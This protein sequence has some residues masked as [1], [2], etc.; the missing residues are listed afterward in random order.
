MPLNSVNTNVAAQ[1]ALK[2]LNTTATQLQ[3]TQKQ[4]STGYRAA[5][6]TD[7]GGAFAVA[8]RVRGDIAALTTVN[9]QLGNAKG[10]VGTALS[11]LTTIS[12]YLTSAKTLLVNIADQSVPQAQRDQYVASYKT[13]IQEVA[14]TTD[15]STYN[16]QTLLGS[17]AGAVAG[18]STS[19]INNE[20]GSTTTLSGED[21][22]TLANTLATFIGSTFSR[23]AA[24]ADSFGTIAAGADQASAATAI[25]GTSG[26]ISFATTLT[27]V[28]NQLNQ[29]GADSNY[30]D[31]TISFNSTKI[32]A[33]NAGLGSLID[34]DLTKESA[35]LQAL[36]IREQ[37]GTQALSL[38]NQA[39]QALLSLFK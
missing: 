30:L 29:A 39:P 20:S 22:S 14:N 26:P 8:Q 28:S 3:A 12:N 36:Q 18:T 33:L 9:Q 16:G 24:G 10:L 35:T 15:G 6:A 31:A 27:A 21:T 17:S 4:I 5:D 1:V 37:L 23:T 32:D 2:S 19:V 7:D 13:L 11:G 38:A 25:T 34:A